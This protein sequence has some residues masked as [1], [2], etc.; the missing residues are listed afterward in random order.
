MLQ[1]CMEYPLFTLIISIVAIVTIDNIFVNMS[2]VKVAKY[3]SK[4]ECE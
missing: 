3:E 2:K 4:K 1:W